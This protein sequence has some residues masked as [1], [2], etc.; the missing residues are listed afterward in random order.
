M[1]YLDAQNTYMCCTEQSWFEHFFYHPSTV[2]CISKSSCF[3]ACWLTTWSA[4]RWAWHFYNSH[5][6]C[7]ACGCTGRFACCDASRWSSTRRCVSIDACRAV[8]AFFSIKGNLS[9]LRSATWE[10]SFQG[11]VQ[12]RG[13]SKFHDLVFQTWEVNILWALFA[14]NRKFTIARAIFLLR[15]FLKQF[16]L[17]TEK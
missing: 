7:L 6:L 15:A 16:Y 3:G 10:R 5:K 2:Q 8:F 14:H 4:A 9:F 12:A 1:K 13:F 11:F 17:H